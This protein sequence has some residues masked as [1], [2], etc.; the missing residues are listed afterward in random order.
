MLKRARNTMPE[1]EL[2]YVLA[3]GADIV[4]QSQS[5]VLDNSMCLLLRKLLYKVMKEVINYF[6]SQQEGA[7]EKMNKCSRTAAIA[8]VAAHRLIAKALQ[9]H[10][11]YVG[12]LL[13]T[14]NMCV[15][16]VS[17]GSV[18]LVRVCILYVVNLTIM[19][20][21]TILNLSVVYLW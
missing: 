2:V 14:V 11:Q 16:Y 12:L 6:K 13:K 10:K 1:T 8:Q 20:L 3:K 21:Y 19:N 17:K 15:G 18:I 5:L 9:I 7:L 4:W